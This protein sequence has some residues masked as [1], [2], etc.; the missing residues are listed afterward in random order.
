MEGCRHER[1]RPRRRA[2]RHQCRWRERLR[3]GCGLTAGLSRRHALVLLLIVLAGAARGAWWVAHIEIWRGDEAQH[4]AYVEQLATGGGIPVVGRD[5]VGE[6]AVALYL[7]STSNGYAAG[8][9][10]PTP[11]VAAWGAPVEQYEGGQGPTYYALLVLPYRLTEGLPTEARL[12][13][14][15]T[16][17]ML[18]LLTTVPVTWLLARAILPDQPV[19]WVLA[20]ALWVTWQGVNV[21]GSG[22]S[23]DALVTPLAAGA[24]AAVAWAWRRGPTL[25]L[26]A[27]AGTAAGLAVVTKATALVLALP[28]A[29][30]AVGAL[31]RHRTHP[32][33]AAAWIAVGGVTAAVPVVPWLLW[34]QRTYA[35]SSAT[36]EFNGIIGPIIGQRA[37]GLDTAVYYLHSTVQSLFSHADFRPPWERYGLLLLGV[38]AIAAIAGIVVAVGRRRG[39]EAFGLAVLAAGFPVGFVTMTAVVV[40]LLDGYGS[41]T[42]RYLNPVLPG[43]AVVIAGGALL[44]LGRRAGVLAVAVVAATAL[45]LEIEHD[46]TY[47]RSIYLR[48]L[49]VAGLA[50]AISQER[51]GAFAADPVVTVTPGCPARLVGLAFRGDPPPAVTAAGSAAPLVAT[52]A[53]AAGVVMA[54]YVVDAS[55]PFEVAVT[56]PEVAISPADRHPAIALRDR[57]GDPVIRVS[58]PARDPESVRYAQTHDPLHPDL[59]YRAVAAWPVAWAVLGWTLAGLALAATAAGRISAAAR[60][61]RTGTPPPAP[62]AG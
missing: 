14:L 38:V 55:A 18:L 39:D 48:G 46:R 40:V 9:N 60:R 54:S 30:L 59:P 33:R 25:P 43:A 26:A 50:P 45:T 52:E 24:A 36:E 62:P 27:A 29:A 13:V 57:P 23:N 47:L 19:A 10:P 22:L 11:E 32:A 44:A 2:A 4:Y 28:L 20:P 21:G 34:Q 15:R 5:T 49:P 37:F 3:R 42:G 35:P 61:R 31:L 58:C 8:D 51:G 6:D 53:L 41:V 16:L 7:R 17:S 12:L 56:A 1:P